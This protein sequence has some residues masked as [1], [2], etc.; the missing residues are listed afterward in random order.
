MEKV[1]LI[2]HECFTGAQNP[3][4]VFTAVFLSPLF[5]VLLERQAKFKT[6]IKVRITTVQ[7]QK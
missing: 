5:I 2:V 6:G 1:T 7:S 3:E 4:E